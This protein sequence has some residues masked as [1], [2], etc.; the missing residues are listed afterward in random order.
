MPP[1]LPR[2]LPRCPSPSRLFPPTIHPSTGYVFLFPWHKKK[3]IHVVCALTLYVFLHKTS[4]DVVW[5]YL[6]NVVHSFSL[7]LSMVLMW[8]RYH[9]TSL[10]DIILKY[11]IPLAPFF[12]L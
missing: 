10:L 2:F 6:N 3:F 4:R 8:F 12:L 1:F 7:S 11:D 9:S 5:L